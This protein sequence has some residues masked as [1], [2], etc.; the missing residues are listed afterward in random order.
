MASCSL[1]QPEKPDFVA[2]KGVLIVF[3]GLNKAQD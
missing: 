3:R 2:P 1:H